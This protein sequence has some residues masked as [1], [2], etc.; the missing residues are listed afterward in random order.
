M[1]N[2][3]NTIDDALLLGAVA[4]LRGRVMA[5]VFGAVC[6]SG[7]FLATAWL[8][9]QGGEAVGSHLNLLSNYFPGYSV[10]WPGAFIG[11][12]YGAALGAVIGW[13]A[14]SVYNRIAMRSRN[15]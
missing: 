11:A 14:A 6:A 10:T 1:T 4:R 15:D 8:L 3:A 7:L 9:V 2:T 13:S 12:L 5:L